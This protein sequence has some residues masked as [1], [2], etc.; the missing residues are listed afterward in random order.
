MMDFILTK[1]TKKIG[2]VALLESQSF[3][4]EIHQS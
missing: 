2:M 3:D 4:N 1:R